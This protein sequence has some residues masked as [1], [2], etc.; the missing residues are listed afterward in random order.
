MTS[1][2]SGEE[3]LGSCLGVPS[4]VALGMSPPVSEVSEEGCELA[5][6]WTGSRVLGKLGCF[7]EQENRSCSGSSPS[8]SHPRGLHPEGLNLAPLNPTSLSW[9]QLRWWVLSRQ[10]REP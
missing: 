5:A 8:S 1:N 2:R 4:R 10:G 7:P 3:A 9:C 6:S